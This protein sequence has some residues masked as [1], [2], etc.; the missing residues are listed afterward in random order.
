MYLR[1]VR[2]LPT[3]VEGFDL[4]RFELLGVYD[5]N[6]PLCDLLIL[7]G[8][9][10]PTDSPPPS[11]DAA[12]KAVADALVSQRTTRLSAQLDEPITPRHSSRKK[13]RRPKH[14]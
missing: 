6:A 10:L 8:Y 14:R 1:I 9:A 13:N 3:T 5:I 12:L 4:T 2:P 7:Y 11:R